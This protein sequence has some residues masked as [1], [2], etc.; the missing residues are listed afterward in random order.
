MATIPAEPL[1]MNVFG[2]WIAVIPGEQ[3][4]VSM[5]RWSGASMAGSANSFDLQSGTG[6]Q[7]E[8][9]LSTIQPG[10]YQITAVPVAA[11]DALLKRADLIEQK[12]TVAQAMHG[13]LEL[14]S[15]QDAIATLQ[16][17][18]GKTSVVPLRKSPLKASTPDDAQKMGWAQFYHWAHGATS[19]P[20]LI[21]RGHQS[22][23]YSLRTRFHRGGRCDLL[24]YMRREIHV[25]HHRVSASMSRRFDLAT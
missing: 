18:S 24:Q 23:L 2:Q 7:Y 1:S 12:D 4:C 14:S 10:K 19:A 8:V 16:T 13:T 17:A 3:L 9:L 21:Y 11:Y 20:H 22:N 6:K 25:L 15:K 5:D